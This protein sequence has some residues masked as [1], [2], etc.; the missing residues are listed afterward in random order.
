M[1]RFL[2]DANPN[3]DAIMGGEQPVDELQRKT[4]TRTFR[5]DEDMSAL[6]ESAARRGNTTQTN[7]LNEILLQ[8]F[9][10]SQY[11]INHDSPFLVIGS[12]TNI[13]LQEL[14]E[15]EKIEKTLRE[16]S[17]QEAR[18]FI[19]YRWR[20]VNFR[21]IVRFLNLLSLYANIGNIRIS[22]ANNNHDNNHGMGNN[23]HSFNGAGNGN[24]GANG[25]ESYEIAVRHHLGRK[26]STFMA[27]Y[28]TTL[29]TSS[30]PG[31]EA[32]YDISRESCFVD[33]KL[34]VKQS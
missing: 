9:S 21:N 12:Q 15:D 11:I 23:N 16:I 1:G 4:V 19:R 31:A 3:F 17:N 20:K 34:P 7:L 33:L 2:I 6:I 29:F 32:T 14:I 30:I 8:Y 28:I 25:F 26:W 13:A 24:N 10:W 18:D 5:I 27:L 22:P